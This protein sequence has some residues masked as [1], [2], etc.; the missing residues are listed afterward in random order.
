MSSLTKYELQ[1]TAVLH[2][3]D[4]AGNLL[5]ADGADGKPD[6][7]KPMRVHLY[8]SGS[9]QYAIALRKKLEG[10][11]KESIDETIGTNAEFLAD[12]TVSLDNV[13]SDHGNTG[14]ALAIEIYR[15][16]RLSFL[17]EQIIVFLNETANF[18]KPSTSS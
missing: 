16:Q 13:D 17:R 8:G 4:G 10:K 2:F 18:A 11:A 1:E 12:C 9:K 6:L 5:Y 15:N 7:T 3:K 14:K